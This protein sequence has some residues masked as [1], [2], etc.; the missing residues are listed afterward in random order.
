M[1][2]KSKKQCAECGKPLRAVRGAGRKRRYCSSK[3]RDR[4]RRSRNFVATG[5]TRPSA[6]RNG[7]N[8]AVF[9]GVFS[10]RIGGRANPEAPKLD[11]GELW[12]A[13]VETETGLLKPRPGQQAALNLRSPDRLPVIISAPGHQP[14][15]NDNEK[16]S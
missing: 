2:S 13:I 5:Y 4:A 9:S 15:S 3:C 6:T 12:Q 10:N 16:T 7:K 11:D 1:S 8:N 14:P